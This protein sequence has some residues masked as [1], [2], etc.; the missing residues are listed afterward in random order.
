[1]GTVWIGVA[2]PRGTKTFKK[3]YRNDRKRNIERFA[4]TALNFLR[5]T[6]IEDSTN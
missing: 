4:A 6:L 2:G 5:L 1:V 3:V